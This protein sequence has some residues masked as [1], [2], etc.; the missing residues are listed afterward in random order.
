V[1]DGEVTSYF[2][3]MGAGHYYV[4]ARSGAMHGQ[5]SGVRDLYYGADDENLYLRLD[6]EG[7]PETKIELR[8]TQGAIPLLGNPQVESALRKILELRVP[9]HLL[10]VSKDQPLRFQVAFGNDIIPAEGWME[11]NSPS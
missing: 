5:R 2:E 11:L 4:D 1:I 6:L 3:W 10:G 9:F 8:T 7:A